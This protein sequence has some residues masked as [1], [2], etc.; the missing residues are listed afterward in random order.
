MTA[1]QIKDE[2]FNVVWSACDTFRGVI[3]PSDYKNY[4]LTLLFVKYLSDAR[5]AKL[6]EFEKKYKGDQ[7]R[8]ER[9][10]ARE[11]FVIPENC[12]FDFLYAHREDTDIGQ[13]INTV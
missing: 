1:Q 12:S 10:M 2:I 13:V 3:D 4:I 7:T 8:I 6:E 9:A 11:R 5:K